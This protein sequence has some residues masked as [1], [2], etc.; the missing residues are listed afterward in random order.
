MYMNFSTRY[1]FPESVN[2]KN[3]EDV[4]TTILYTLYHSVSKLQ[5]IDT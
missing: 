3:R 2:F 4:W 5:P 1:D